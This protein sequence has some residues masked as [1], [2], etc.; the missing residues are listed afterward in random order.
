M[1]LSDRRHANRKSVARAG[2]LSISTKPGLG[3]GSFAL[4]QRQ[5][6]PVALLLQVSD[7]DESQCGRV[8][9]V[10]QPSGCGAVVEDVA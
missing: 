4:E 1:P 5:V 10:T 6:V 9:A 3:R 2:A 7:R 8:D